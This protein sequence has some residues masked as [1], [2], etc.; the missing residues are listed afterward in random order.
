MQSL[1]KLPM[2]NKAQN[3]RKDICT[4]DSAGEFIAWPMKPVALSNMVPRSRMGDAVG[5]RLLPVTVWVWVVSMLRGNDR[6]IFFFTRF[7]EWGP[8]DVDRRLIAGLWWDFTSESLAGWVRL[9]GLRRPDPSLFA[10]LVLGPSGPQ[11]SGLVKL[12]LIY[13]PVLVCLT[14]ARCK[15]APIIWIGQTRAYLW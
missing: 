11:L 8:R 13:G 1:F 15:W 10:W 9:L 3:K 7:G 6:E 4:T 12:V 5:Y 14:C 2:R